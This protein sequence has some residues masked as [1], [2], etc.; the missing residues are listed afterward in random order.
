MLN[1][2]KCIKAHQKT[3]SFTWEAIAN[4]EDKQRKRPR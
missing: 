2:F 4:E 3:H 1:F